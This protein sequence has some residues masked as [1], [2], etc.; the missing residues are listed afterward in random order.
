[1]TTSV[2]VAVSESRWFRTVGQGVGSG[3]AAGTLLGRGGLRAILHAGRTT[4]I[5]RLL[6][7]PL[8]VRTK[9]Q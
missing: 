3:S 2:C 6:D 8:C 9:Q 7:P 1:M 4:L 5:L